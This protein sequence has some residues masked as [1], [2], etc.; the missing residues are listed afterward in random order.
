MDANMNAFVDCDSGSIGELIAYLAPEVAD[1]GWTGWP[2]D[3]FAVAADLLRQSG[4]Y[5]RV[6]DAD[7]T[8]LG[9]GWPTEARQLG[10]SWRDALN[11]AEAEASPPEDDLGASDT[12]AWAR[13]AGRMPPP[14]PIADLWATIRSGAQTLLSELIRDA[15][16]GTLAA[17]IKLCG[18]ADEACAGIGIEKIRGSSLLA[19]AEP[20]VTMSGSLCIEISVEKLAVLPKKH[21]PQCGLTIRSMSHHLAL[22]PANGLHAQWIP[23]YEM[24]KPAGPL[25]E[26]MNL[27]LLPWPTEIDPATNFE[28]VNPSPVTLPSTFG[29]FR[30][31]REVSDSAGNEFAKRFEAVMDLAARRVGT[32]HGIVLPELALTV[33]EYLE[34]ERVAMDRG[35]FLIA[36]VSEPSGNGGSRRLTNASYTQIAGLADTP[37]LADQMRLKQHKHH[38]WCLDRQQVLQYGLG[39]RLP[40]GRALWEDTPVAKREIAFLNPSRWL[41]L[42]VL[43]CEDLARQD[44]TAET[45]RAVGPNLV[46]ALLMDAPQLRDRW[47]A[48]YAS[49]LAEDPG[50][51]VLTLTSRGMSRLSS[52]KDEAAEDKSDVLALWRDAPHGQREVRIPEGCPGCVLSLAVD[53]GREYTADGRLGSRPAHYPVFAGVSLLP[54]G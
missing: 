13:F 38:R 11:D 20:L 15:N 49:I 19:V 35:A 29:L 31:R 53:E 22:R 8:L 23:P 9:P 45:I 30:Y 10:N 7:P 33:E 4:A 12:K 25:E 14:T 2:P 46:I 21:T 27:L 28:V 26:V 37:V 40:A 17:L 43:I 39:A 32:V 42:S 3:A 1:R 50:C 34:A 18:I 41:T 47:P 16:R 52:P 5:V 51:S 44:P 36:G 54:D 6:I 48:R 24:P